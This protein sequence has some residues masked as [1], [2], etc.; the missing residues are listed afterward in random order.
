[1]QTTELGAWCSEGH[2]G[3]GSGS[4]GRSDCRGLKD[5]LSSRTVTQVVSPPPFLSR[6]WDRGVPK[7]DVCLQG[8]G[9]GEAGGRHSGQRTDS[10][11]VSSVLGCRELTGCGAE[12]EG[13]LRDCQLAFCSDLGRGPFPAGGHRERARLGS[14]SQVGLW[15]VSGT[16][17][18][19]ERRRRMGPGMLGAWGQMCGP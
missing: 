7:A 19:A 6:P 11:C 10:R 5:P 18:A 1:M 2:M 17:E 15:R 9:A 3:R 16:C 4:R 12:R 13:T 14:G 8:A